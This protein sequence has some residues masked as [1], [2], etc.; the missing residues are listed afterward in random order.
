MPSYRDY[1]PFLA[2]DNRHRS[3]TCLA[4]VKRRMTKRFRDAFLEALA[5]TGTSLR[6]V[7]SETGISED[8]LKKLKQRESAST[9]VDDAIKVA[10]FF[11][12]TLDEFLE[13]ETV[14]DRAEIVRLYMQLSPRE[15]AILRAASREQGEPAPEESS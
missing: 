4:E 5:A 11:G 13:D 15:R 3:A 12:Y 2:R 6:K 8:Q 9:N 10:N 14:Q 1:C 7:A